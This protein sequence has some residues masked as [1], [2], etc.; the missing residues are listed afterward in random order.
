VPERYI[1]MISGDFLYDP[2]RLPPDQ[3]S[4]QNIYNRKTLET[5]WE[6][7]HSALSP[8]TRQCF[9]VKNAI[10]QTELREEM[11]E[12]IN[13]HK[14]PTNTQCAEFHIIADYTKILDENEMKQ[15]L[16]TLRNYVI[17]ERWTKEKQCW[18]TV[19]KNINLVR[20][21]CQSN[22]KNIQTFRCLHGYKYFD[23]IVTKAL[24]Y[25]RLHSNSED[26]SEAGLLDICK[27][28]VRTVDIIGLISS[29][30]VGENSMGFDVISGLVSI[31]GHVSFH[32]HGYVKMQTVVLRLYCK[33]FSELGGDTEKALGSEFYSNALNV[34]G[35]IA[36]MDK[37]N[38]TEAINIMSEDLNHGITIL[39]RAWIKDNTVVRHI[40][41]ARSLVDAVILC[42]TR[43]FEIPDE[44]GFTE[45]QIHEAEA[46]R[47]HNSEALEKGLS[48]IK[49]I[50]IQGGPLADTLQDMEIVKDVVGMFKHFVM[51]S[52]NF[53]L[54]CEKGCNKFDECVH[55]RISQIGLEIIQTIQNRG[56]PLYDIEPLCIYSQ[57][58]DEIYSTM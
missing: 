56:G 58:I 20:L 12:Y 48:L 55:F 35:V 42:I 30:I 18:G 25:L 13:L 49:E 17:S 28:I 44:K 46:H 36:A 11:K 15:L 21:Y 23:Q 8:Y 9:H 1:D 29:D 33:I 5:I 34:K 38:C 7:T 32:H 14:F 40:D 10:P 16:N 26:N 52:R 53:P 57:I 24:L 47:W 27:E 3:D 50:M 45:G 19:W 39:R 22:E 41:Y 37:L 31:L 54:F 51:D 4:S 43:E 2:V 6:T